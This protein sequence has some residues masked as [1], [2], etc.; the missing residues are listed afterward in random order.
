MASRTGRSTSG[1]WPQGRPLYVTPPPT[2]VEGAWFD[3]AAVERVLAVFRALRHTKGRWAKARFELDPWQI[4]WWVRPVFGWKHPDGTRIVRR[5]WFEVPRKNGKSTAAAAFALVLLSADGEEGAEVYSAAASLSQAEIVF[6]EAKK[7]ARAAPVLRGRLQV[8]KDVLVYPRTGGVYRALSRMADAAHGL[9]VSGAVVDEVHVH[10]GRD[11]IDAIETGTGARSQPLVL[12][13]TTAGDGDQG[14][15]YA[16]LHGYVQR[17]AE[18]VIADPTTYGAIWAAAEADDPFAEATWRKANPGLGLTISVDYLRKEAERARS[19]PAYFGSFCRLHLNR[20]VGAASRYLP[21]EQ[22]DATENAALMDLDELEGQACYA[23]LDLSST[24]DMTALALVFPRADGRKTVVPYYWMP[25]ESLR[26]RQRRD[27]VPYATWER[28]GHLV[29]TPG[30]VVDYE[31]VKAKLRELAGRFTIRELAYDP[32]NATQLVLELQDEG[33]TCIPL[34]QGYA[35]LSAP[36]KDL[37]AHVL[38]GRWHHGGNPVLRW[39]AANLVVV[40]D[41]AGNVKPNKARSTGRIDGLAAAINA[42]DRAARYD[43]PKRSI[44]ETRGLSAV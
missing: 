3:E 18:G 22:W 25:E 27:R 15:I 28:M 6:N 30:N 26:E 2:D 31:A 13:I 10:K 40:T 19:T 8:L 9:N 29:A 35:S 12:F 17:L 41:P 16:E 23:G 37:L 14:T 43:A 32:W 24:T 5:A 21:L 39:N 38:A 7:M 36:T 1:D 44:Y 4:E 20:Q 33:F 42:L 11:L 34:R